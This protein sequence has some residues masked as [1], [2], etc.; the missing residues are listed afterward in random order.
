MTIQYFGSDWKY[1]IRSGDYLVI[2]MLDSI[3]DLDFGDIHLL[4]TTNTVKIK[5]ILRL[6]D[7]RK[8]II[9]SDNDEKDKEGNFIYQ[10]YPLSTGLVIEIGKVVV[11]I[12]NTHI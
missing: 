4:G 6:T 3:D 9:E 11:I 7:D 12:S 8:L 10:N 1:K 2:K 5:R